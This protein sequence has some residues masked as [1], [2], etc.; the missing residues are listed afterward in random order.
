VVLVHG[1]G[2]TKAWEFSTAFLTELYKTYPR[3]FVIPVEYGV[4]GV[5]NPIGNQKASLLRCAGL[6][7]GALFG[8]IDDASL[9]IRRDWS[10][11]RYDIVGH[12]QGGLIL[13]YLAQTASPQRSSDAFAYD[14]HAFLAFPIPPFKSLDN[15]YRGHFDRIITIGAPHNGSLLQFYSTALL[16]VG[17]GPFDKFPYYLFNNDGNEKFDPFGPEIE[18]INS[19]RCDTDRD[20]RFNCVR[21]RIYGGHSAGDPPAHPLLDPSPLVYWFMDKPVP[22]E[23]NPIPLFESLWGPQIPTP[24]V[25]R[26]GHILL[27]EGSDGVVDFDSQRGG[28]EPSKNVS[29]LTSYGDIAHMVHFWKVSWPL[30]LLTGWPYGIRDRNLGGFLFSVDDNYSQIDSRIMA[31]KISYLLSG[32]KD[33]FGPFIKANLRPPALKAAIKAMVSTPPIEVDGAIMISPSGLDPLSLRALIQSDSNPPLDGSVVW[34][35]EHYGRDGID[36]AGFTLQT[37]VTN[38]NAAILNITPGLIGEIAVWA[39]YRDT[40]GNAVVAMPVRAYQNDGGASLTSISLGV[41]NI[42]LVAGQFT[43]AGIAGTYD[44]GTTRPLLSLPDDGLIY[45]SSGT[46]VADFASN[47]EIRALNPGLCTVTVT[48]GGLSASSSVEVIPSNDDFICRQRINPGRTQGSNLN[49]SNETGETNHAG[50]AGG[51]SVWFSWTAPGAGKATIDTIGSSFN[52]LLAVYTNSSLALL[53]SVASSSGS[54]TNGSSRVTFNAAPGTQYQ[55]AVDGFNGSSGN[56]YLNLIFTLQGAPT[57][58]NQPVDKTVT[59]G[60]SATFTIEATG[61]A[62]LRYQWMKDGL[63][64]TDG[65]RHSPVWNLGMPVVTPSSL[66]IK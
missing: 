10:L 42:S 26:T 25:V 4:A 8:A 45:S 37:D 1:I 35:A 39:R 5:N 12:S 17:I 36:V 31:L 14:G 24:T 46:N 2:S 64:L 3:D 54:G 66:P 47:G 50:N 33:K 65:G 63:S 58:T 20:A 18:E 51:R 52:T 62:P 9:P 34:S 7:Q 40:N 61:N 13:R 28:C 30:A 16:Q 48:R 55:I 29:D 53:E 27:P 15:Y 21:T 44:D 57:I 11:T 38:T 56:I 60:N 22:N 43:I 49:A 19:G 41:T 32:P 59:N 23:L 6:L